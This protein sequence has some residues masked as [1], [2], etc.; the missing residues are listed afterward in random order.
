MR[1]AAI[2]AL[3]GVMLLLTA[4][5]SP[6]RRVTDDVAEIVRKTR[7]LYNATSGAEVKFV[8]EGTTGST[9]GTLVYGQGNRFR[10]EFPKQTIV[11]NG[12]RTWTYYS[13]KN[14]VMISRASS[15]R[16]RLMPSDIMTA[17][18]GNYSTKLIGQKSVNGRQVWVVECL[19]GSGE[20]IGDITRAVLYID[21]GTFRFQQ[22]DIESPTIG[23]MKLRITSARYDLKLPDS[24]FTFTP[25]QNARV[26]DLSK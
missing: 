4:S 14:Q 5:P 24:R 1:T 16:G 23:A 12:E 13:E 19:P 11:S 3:A 10:L 8:Q 15:G 22:I 6:A 7:S 26:V 17:F 18:P 25:P 20:K 2:T 9:S 21:K